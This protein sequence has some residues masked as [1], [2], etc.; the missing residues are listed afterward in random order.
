MLRDPLEMACAGGDEDPRHARWM[1]P[2]DCP[3]YP[4]LRADDDDGRRFARGLSL[5]LCICLIVYAA[6]AA[7]WI[8]WQ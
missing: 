6:G 8:W 4:R 7:A 3:S 2:P 5:A 1:P